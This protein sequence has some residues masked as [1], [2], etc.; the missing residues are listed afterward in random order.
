MTPRNVGL[1]A[2]RELERRD[3]GAE[4]LLQ[5]VERAVERRALA[6]E[7]VDEDHA[8]D[9]A[10]LGHLPRDLGLHLDALDRGDDA[11]DE[12]DRAQRRGD[13]ADEVGVARACR[14]RFT[15]WPSDSNGASASDTEMRRRASSGSKSQTVLPSS[16]RPTR[17]I[18]PAREQQRLGQRG[19]PGAAVPDEGDV[20]D[21][22]GRERLHARPPAVSAVRRRRCDATASGRRDRRQSPA[23]SARAGRRVGPWSAG[24]PQ[25]CVVRLFNSRE[26]AERRRDCD[27]RRPDERDASKH[28]RRHAAAPASRKVSPRSA[29]GS[30]RP[31][32]SANFLTV[33]GLVCSVVTAFLIATG[34]LRWAVLGLIA[35]GF[36]DLLDGAVA[37]RT[38]QASPAGAFFDSV[39]DRVSDAVVLGGVAWYLA[40]ESPYLPILA[41][42]AVAL[43]MLISY[44]RA[45]AEGLGYDARGGLMERAERMVLLGIAL[46]FDLLVPALWLM[47]VLTSITAVQRFVKVWR[48][49]SDLPA[50]PQLFAARHRRA[51]GPT[52]RRADRVTDARPVARAA[53]AGRAP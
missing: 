29:R 45:R 52:P 51:S 12:V 32:V 40:G 28:A 1:L 39:T 50:R 2:D 42:A 30:S 46:F 22:R 37:R 17:G 26:R 21:L 9:A 7:L 48:Q 11:H 34:E 23:G 5:L 8:R 53:G 44:E 24:N 6:V 41:F 13:V 10:L 3:A 18:A 16:T 47:I 14:R 27:A 35:S 43:S 31:G 38:G 49:A 4:L 33:V 20:A 36:V 15:L 19:L 25:G